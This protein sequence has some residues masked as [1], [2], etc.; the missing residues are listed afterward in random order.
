[1]FIEESSIF[2]IT[3]VKIGVIDWLLGRK[4]GLIYVKMFE[5]L[6]LRNHT[7]DVFVMNFHNT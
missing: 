1:M 3:F 6:L 2:H 4:K 7:E 5:N